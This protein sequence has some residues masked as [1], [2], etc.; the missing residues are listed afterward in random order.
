M[1]IATGAVRPRNDITFARGTVW[2]RRADRGVRPYGWGIDGAVC[3]GTHGSRPT[4]HYFV[5]Q[6]PCALPGV[7]GKNPPVTASP[8]QPPLGKGAEGTGDAD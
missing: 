5:G 8:C 4:L 3:G 6:G 7:R 1:R 2:N